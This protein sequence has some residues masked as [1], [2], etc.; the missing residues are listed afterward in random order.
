MAFRHRQH[1]RWLRRWRACAAGFS[2]VEVLVGSVLLM[3]VASQSLSL[4]STSM[5][6]T[7]KAKVRDGLNAAIH[8]DLE[9]VRHQVA[10]W[11]RG[12]NTDGQLSYAPSTTACSQANL[13]ST[14]L[15][16]KASDLPVTSLVDLS[17]AP[18]G[19]RSITIHRSISTVP[20]NANL[21]QVNYSTGN[22]SPINVAQRATLSIPAQGWCA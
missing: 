17:T 13:A 11:A 7:G 1:Q 16:E 6:A 12:N 9:L 5:Q 22:N 2:Q 14:L 4:F 20:G 15:A 21:L 8:S 18:Q 3:L 19:L 10:D